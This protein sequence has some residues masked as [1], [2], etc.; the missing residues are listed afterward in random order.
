[1]VSQVKKKW[2]GV[3]SQTTVVA[4]VHKPYGWWHPVIGEGAMVGGPVTCLSNLVEGNFHVE[5]GPS[6]E[7][8]GGNAW[9][10]VA[11]TYGPN[12]VMVDNNH[13]TGISFNVNLPIET[14]QDNVVNNNDFDYQW[15]GL[16]LFRVAEGAPDVIAEQYDLDNIALSLYDNSTNYL[17]LGDDY[18]ETAAR[19][20]TDAPGVVRFAH[21]TEPFATPTPGYIYTHAYAPQIVN[22]DGQPYNTVITLVDWMPSDVQSNFLGEAA[23]S[24]ANEAIL[25]VELKVQSGTNDQYKVYVESVNGSFET[26][27]LMRD[28][29]GGRE[30][31]FIYIHFAA[32]EDGTHVFV[33]IMEE[34]GTQKALIDAGNI[35]TLPDFSM[36][37]STI[38]DID[39]ESDEYDY[40]HIRNKSPGYALNP[41][42]FYPGTPVELSQFGLISLLGMKVG[43]LTGNNYSDHYANHQMDAASEEMTPD[44]NGRLSF[45]Y[46]FSVDVP[47][48]NQKDWISPVRL[49]AEYLT[50]DNFQ[51]SDYY[52]SNNDLLAEMPKGD[53]DEPSSGDTL[54]S[55]YMIG[56]YIEAG[57]SS[58]GIDLIRPIVTFAPN[59]AGM[60][61]L[62]YTSIGSYYFDD[63]QGGDGLHSNAEDTLGD[64]FTP[65]ANVGSGA[66]ESSVNAV[67][68]VQ[69][70]VGYSDTPA[71]SGFV[72]PFV[73]RSLTICISYDTVNEVYEV[74][75]SAT[76]DEPLI[77]YGFNK[78]NGK[79]PTRLMAYT[80]QET[81]QDSPFQ[82]AWYEG[83]PYGFVG[84]LS[85]GIT[86]CPS[87][88]LNGLQP[89]QP[90]DLT[91]NVE[92]TRDLATTTGTGVTVL[93]SDDQVGDKFKIYGLEEEQKIPFPP[94]PEDLEN[95][96]VVVYQKGGEGHASSTGTIKDA[97]YKVYYKYE[98]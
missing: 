65:S 94:I 74:Y 47:E 92:Y 19:V 80:A 51:Q 44:E 75:T 11:N 28:V 89:S 26:G 54:V 45:Y 57:Y 66:G 16:R 1:M 69:G 68:D 48:E 90:V 79:Q 10:Y 84:K 76:G 72:F 43:T 7:F 96:V 33:E 27:T 37:W 58:S 12:A 71:T 4:D 22:S 13:G 39:G 42:E 98:W 60:L 82:N 50:I 85:Q 49:G 67:E 86:T 52:N 61:M 40:T 17:R 30:F 70:Y 59:G 24:W 32:T 56:N 25:K 23:K 91:G 35:G 81:W 53:M 8:S 36:F 29:D 62:P 88:I 46:E 93:P 97:R 31:A 5:F 87:V 38:E 3:L 63:T 34:D 41:D 77:R 9:I 21:A 73:G 64:W 95:K 55:K 83:V 14:V 2:P 15:E 78:F 6:G 18:F 20:R